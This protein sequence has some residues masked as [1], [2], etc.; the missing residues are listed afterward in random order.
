MANKTAVLDPEELLSEVILSASINEANKEVEEVAKS[1]E[2]Q[3][4][5]ISNHII[6]TD[7]LKNLKHSMK[8]HFLL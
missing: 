8:K 1:S 3:L 2:R 7:C 4:N 6:E 5:D